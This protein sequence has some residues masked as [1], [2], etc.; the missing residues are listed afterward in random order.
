MPRTPIYAPT[1]LGGAELLDL[2]VLQPTH[3]LQSLQQHLRRQD[4][5]GM[6]LCSNFRALQVLIGSATPFLQLNPTQYSHY[7]DTS[8]RWKYIWDAS[9]TFHIT[10]KTTFSW[11]PL[12]KYGAA[13][14]CL[15]DTA[16]QHSSFSHDK[17]K[18]HAINACRIYLQVF[19]LS[20]MVTY[21]G[22]H[23]NNKYL[24][25][26]I[27]NPSP[28]CIFPYQPY[29]TKYQWGVWRTFITGTFLCS[30][31]QL[32]CPL[33]P[34][35][36]T[37]Y[38]S[39][40]SPE[41]TLHSLFLQSISHIPPNCTLD[42]AITMLPTFYQFLLQGALFAQDPK[43]LV[44]I[45]EGMRLGTLT[46][47]T[48]G[49]LLPH[50]K[51]GSTGI[52]LCPALDPTQIYTCSS[53]TPFTVHTSSLTS[54]HYGLLAL[55]AL[56]HLVCAL[57]FQQAH[58][59]GGAI[60]LAPISVFIDNKE[61]V[62]RGNRT[63]TTRLTLKEHSVS[64]Y[65][66]WE[67]TNDMLRSLPVRINCEWVKSH[68]DDDKPVQELDLPAQLNVAADQ[69]ANAAHTATFPV[70]HMQ[71]P[72]IDTSVIGFYDVKGEEILDISSHVTTEL[73]TRPM[74]EYLSQKYNWTTDI[75]NNISWD[76]LGISMR[77]LPTTQRLKQLQY[78]HN[79]QNVGQQKI[80]FAQSTAAS[81]GTSLSSA[82]LQD[83]H[84]CPLGCGKNEVQGHYLLC[85]SSPAL[86]ARELS[87]TCIR[88]VLK[89]NNTC[90]ILSHVMSMALQHDV[91]PI[92][93]GKCSSPYNKD[94]E[95]L[96]AA[97]TK[98]G[99]DAFRRGF[100]SISWSQLQQKYASLELGLPYFDHNQWSAMM[101]QQLWDHS[102]AMWDLRNEGLHGATHD[103]SRGK[104]ILL[105]RKRVKQLY[106]H[107][108][109]KFIPPSQRAQYFGLPYHQRKKQGIFALT[110]WIQLVER[111]L[112]FHREEAM[113]RTIHA[114]LEKDL[115]KDLPG[116]GT[117]S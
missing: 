97:Q 73:H 32:H 48:D 91:P 20:D 33:N 115:R 56:L 94:I 102:R 74:I 39:I 18:L 54:E 117:R 58:S 85:Q 24:D 70:P 88:R 40:Y 90:P 7:I 22:R 8:N 12:S 113:K 89:D 16:V 100:I 28:I 78:L 14:T 52:V 30:D 114:W 15:M 83:L 19:F 34:A 64:D 44:D 80:L 112:H 25:G 69:R 47:A 72:F 75:I 108:D 105:L 26:S 68:Q 71:K 92:S 42:V 81:N 111:R 93:R 23:L 76:S 101:V 107:E 99:W 67:L 17:H 53:P 82:T 86:K 62:K 9:Y 37:P 43:A 5:T 6:S 57:K 1:S 4:A 50:S 95:K 77:R 49:S 110:A 55:G 79:W 63:K 45:S 29:P 36:V 87:L 84:T 59:H 46:A 27:R 21:T 65:D 38:N 66:L 60:R 11:T 35:M 41:P 116:T 109:R 51:K 13:D 2:R 106:S 31:N 3:Q 98:I 96:M 61:L 10:V 104:R 103:E